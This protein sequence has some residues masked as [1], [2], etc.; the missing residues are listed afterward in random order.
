M[1]LFGSLFTGVSALGAQ[2]QATAMISNNI[3]NVNTTGFKRS[4][5]SFNSLVTTEG[6]SS[7]YSPGTVVANRIQRV[8]Q[9]GSISQSS[10]STDAAISGNG[11]FAVKRDGDDSALTEFL[12]TR[13]GQFSEDAQGFLR[14]SAGFYLYGW[15]IDVNGDL[16]ANQ[17]DLT[18][19][20]PVDVA[21]LGGLTRP[22]TTAELA[23]NLDASELDQTLTGALTGTVDFQRGLTVYDSL[24][25]AQ[26]ITFEYIK[27]YGPMAT[28]ASGTTNFSATDTLVGDLALTNGHQFTVES[29]N[30]GPFTYEVWDGV[31]VAP[32]GAIQTIGELISA[33]NTDFAAAVPADE[34]E[35]FI[36]NAGELVIQRTEFRSGAANTLI[37]SEGGV[38]Q[39]ALADLGFA[40]SDEDANVATPNTLTVVSDDLDSTTYSNGGPADN[41]SYSGEEFPAFQNYYGDA[42]YN[43]RGWWQI[44]IRDPLNN[45]LTRGIVNFNSDGTIN[46]L[47][48]AEGNVDI[49][50]GGST[51]GVDWGNG[52]SLQTISIDVSRFSQ[53]NSDYTVLFSDQN[54][55]E[56]GLRT[57]IELDRE[58]FVIAR[59]SNGASSRLY[60]LPLVTFANQNGLQEVSGTAYTETEESGEENLREAGTGGAGFVEP[61]TLENSNVDL[62]DEFAKLIVSQRAFSAGSKI[63]STVDQMTEELLRL[64]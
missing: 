62:A 47:E 61:S 17:G 32:A 34:V 63:I 24:G 18:S 44:V 35:A 9:Q 33:I 13:N 28:A 11:F 45:E 43:A 53:F 21:F 8:D 27:T 50:L 31:G 59:F 4:E 2:S 29:E 15:P 40:V 5:A 42:N 26:P 7:R 6:R 12:Y 60:K 20:V 48:D 51:G 56:L 55:A 25:S 10:S 3:A 1:G 19:L 14:N 30:A 64:R 58:G 57:G 54:G 39:T 36:G 52:S 38:G 46:A 22:T 49:E 37:I 16:P 41:P 23:I